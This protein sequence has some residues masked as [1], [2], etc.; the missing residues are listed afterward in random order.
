MRQVFPGVPLRREIE[1][2][3]TLLSIDRARQAL[4]F[5]PQHTWR[6]HVEP[7]PRA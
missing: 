7:E 3:A 1:G 6:D 2:H 5:E 4:G